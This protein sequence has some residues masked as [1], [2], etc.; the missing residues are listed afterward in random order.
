MKT[1]RKKCAHQRICGESSFQT[2]GTLPLQQ[3]NCIIFSLLAHFKQE[4]FL[5]FLI[6]CQGKSISEVRGLD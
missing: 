3:T 4:D 6:G 5:L 2:I 1:E